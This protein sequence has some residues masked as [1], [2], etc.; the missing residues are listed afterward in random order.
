[1]SRKHSTALGFGAA[2]GGAATP[3]AVADT[4][5]QTPQTTYGITKSI[6]ELLVNDYS[7]KGFIDGRS[8]RLPATDF[9]L[10]SPT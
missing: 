7:R 2:F 8:A 1:M 4:T 3:K 6:G 5:K 9:R 10:P